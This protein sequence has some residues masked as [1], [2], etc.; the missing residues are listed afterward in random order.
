MGFVVGI[1][2]LPLIVA[3]KLYSKSSN[4]AISKQKGFRACYASA[5][6]TPSAG[7][8]T[9]QSHGACVCACSKSSAAQPASCQDQ[10]LS[11]R[12]PL[13]GRLPEV[14]VPLLHCT[15]LHA[16]LKGHRLDSHL[17]RRAVAAV[18]F[19]FQHQAIQLLFVGASCLRHAG[20][21]PVAFAPQCQ[22][23]RPSS[24]HGP[25]RP[26]RDVGAKSLPP[27]T[28]LSGQCPACGILAWTQ[29]PRAWPRV[30]H[31]SP[32]PCTHRARLTFSSSCPQTESHT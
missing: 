17:P 23:D 20:H 15:L 7:S 5:D 27:Q 24:A 18:S 2:H 19:L 26:S 11:C 14:L 10:S 8:V 31:S 13:H 25:T 12:D 21:D 22:L 1:E 30:W 29:P 4:Y 28:L 32:S 6:S 16:N 9:V 3:S